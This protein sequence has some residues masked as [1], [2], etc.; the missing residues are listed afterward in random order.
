MKE[1]DEGASTGT[2]KG[3]VVEHRNLHAVI[4]WSA[5]DLS[6]DELRGMPAATS[7]CCDPSRSF[8]ANIEMASQPPGHAV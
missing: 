3:V 7:V 2:P 5:D 1:L 4:H 6:A 8:P